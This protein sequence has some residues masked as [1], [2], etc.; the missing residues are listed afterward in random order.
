VDC[1]GAKAHLAAGTHVSYHHSASFVQSP[2][3]LTSILLLCLLEVCGIGEE[4]VDDES[5]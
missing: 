4:W 2:E 1:R 3:Y 5:E